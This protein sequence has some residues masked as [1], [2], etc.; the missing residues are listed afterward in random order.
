MIPTEL[1]ALK[2]SIL[3]DVRVMMQTTGQVTQYIGARY[4]PLIADPIEWSDQKEYEPLTIVTNQGN[5]YTSRQ[6]VPKGTPITNEQFWAATGNFNAQIEQYRQE[7]AKFDSRIT[8][9]QNAADSKAPINH[10]T[11]STEYGVGNSMNYGHVKLADDADSTYGANDGVAATPA[12][13]NSKIAHTAIPIP[14]APYIS[15]MS[16]EL[17]N[18]STQSAVKIND[19]IY[20]GAASPDNKKQVI[21]KLNLKT[22]VVNSTE[23]NIDS[24]HM[25]SM[26]YDGSYLVINRNGT[27]IDFYDIDSLAL[28]K[29]VKSPVFSIGFDYYNGTWYGYNYA[30]GKAYIYIFNGEF[31]SVRETITIPVINNL[32]FPS[33]TITVIDDELCYI[34]FTHMFVLINYKTKEIVRCYTSQSGIEFEQLI[35]VDDNLAMLYNIN[36]GIAIGWFS[37]TATSALTLGDYQYKPNVIFDNIDTGRYTSSNP[38]LLYLLACE[39]NKV[40]NT[41]YDFRVTIRYNSWNANTSFESTIPATKIFFDGVRAKSITFANCTFGGCKEI[42]GDGKTSKPYIEIS[43][44][45]MKGASHIDFSES[46]VIE[47]MRVTIEGDP[48]S[49]NIPSN[50]AKK[51]IVETLQ[52][53]RCKVG[54]FSGTKCLMPI[55]MKNE[56][57]SQLDSLVVTVKKSDTEIDINLSNKGQA[58]SFTRSGVG[59][60]SDKTPVYIT[61]KI[62][63]NNELTVNVSDGFTPVSAYI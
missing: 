44:M 17:I 19:T 4:V 20:V 28:I 25:N 55:P 34:G 2:Q 33:Q 47:N 57:F 26:A 56:T 46:D 9:A 22:Q 53:M 15:Y 37:D 49:V 11:D 3:D 35:K 16:D 51:L 21:T 10:A 30:G 14:Y 38:N 18:K 63:D 42:I 41:D 12:Y 39:N 24:C 61:S 23:L 50:K 36:G 13:V 52:F 58:H 31:E 62:N 1:Q 32:N 40:I 27:D 45:I 7:V 60:T 54:D 48:N 43:N 8:A 29:S 6:F 59:V 5:S